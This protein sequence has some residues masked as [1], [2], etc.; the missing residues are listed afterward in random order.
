MLPLA[1]AQVHSTP[2]R[3]P[4]TGCERGLFT[5]VF[6]DLQQL[7]LGGGATAPVV[8]TWPAPGSAERLWCL[9]ISHPHPGVTR[10]SPIGRT[11]CGRVLIPPVHSSVVSPSFPFPLLQQVFQLTILGFCY[12][13][14]RVFVPVCL[15]ELVSNLVYTSLIHLSK[16]QKPKHHQFALSCRSA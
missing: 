6:Y 13:F 14:F 4:A 3:P 10:V 12:P 5:A 7:L 2:P 8:H 16:L 1:T 15:L 11:T 9:S